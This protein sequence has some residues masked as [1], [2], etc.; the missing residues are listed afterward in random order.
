MGR[1]RPHPPPPLASRP[2]E[3][4]EVAQPARDL[5]SEEARGPRGQ[6]LKAPEARGSGS[7]F[8]FKFTDLSAGCTFSCPPPLLPFTPSFASPLAAAPLHDH[9]SPPTPF[10]PLSLL[11]LP[12]SPRAL[13]PLL[14]FSFR[15]PLVRPASATAED[16]R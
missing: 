13:L 5:G 16:P 11:L 2:R 9:L 14:R 15:V 3:P 6:V 4:A 7:V 12:P 8:V 10:F 1:Q